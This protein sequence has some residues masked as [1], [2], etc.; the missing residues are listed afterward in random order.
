VSTDGD[1]RD[2][3]A[4]LEAAGWRVTR[5]SKHWRLT[6]PDGAPT[7]SCPS[8]PG[9]PGANVWYLRKLLSGKVPQ[10]SQEEHRNTG[11]VP[12]FTCPHCR[13]TSHNPTDV[14]ERYCGRCNHFCDD[15]D[16]LLSTMGGLGG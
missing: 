12:S 7:V 3:L 5:G 4:A 10:S 16:L 1:V 2:L 6:H 13:A 14:R 8:T 15:Y 11:A 9:N